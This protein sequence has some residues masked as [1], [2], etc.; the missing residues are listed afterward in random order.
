MTDLIIGGVGILPQG[1]NTSVKVARGCPAAGHGH[2]GKDG[3]L[4]P[5]HG[6]NN[7]RKGVEPSMSGRIGHNTPPNGVGSLDSDDCALSVQAPNVFFAID[8]GKCPKQVN[9]S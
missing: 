9:S 8:D 6:D 1:D 2:S 5:P 4:I 3:G 7:P